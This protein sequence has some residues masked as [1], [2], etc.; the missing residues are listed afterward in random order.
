MA[1]AP[2]I[3]FSNINLAQTPHIARSLGWLGNFVRE[4]GYDGVEYTPV[5]PHRHTPRAI[6]RAVS[7]KSIDIES[8]HATFRTTKPSRYLYPDPSKKEDYIPGM[9]EKVLASPF[10]GLIMP[11]AVKSAHFMRRTQRHM[12]RRVPGVLYPLADRQRDIAQREAAGISRPFFQP[13]EHQVKMVHASTLQ[14]FHMEMHDIR[15]Y[16]YVADTVHIRKRYGIDRPGILNDTESSLPFMAPY[17]KA[18]HLSLYRKDIPGEDHI[19]GLQEARAALRGEYTG[20]LRFM[21]DVL[22]ER[23]DIEY[24]VVEGTADAIGE[25]VEATSIKDL[26]HAYRD[27]AEGFVDYWRAA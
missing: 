2:K 5:L 17:T 14:G 15:N 22:K 26:Q 27:I 4:A 12:G 10:G 18:M 3:L 25:A 21:L 24:V 16:E 7:R 6:G 8:L 23:G 1:E 9:V 11:D 20:E 13:M 19:P